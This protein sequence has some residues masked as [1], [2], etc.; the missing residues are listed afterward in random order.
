MSFEPR[1]VGF[2]CN[3]CSYA[4]ADGAGASR[5]PY[6]QN[7]SSIRVMCSAR[8]EPGLVLEA[9]ALGA[10]GVLVCGCHPGDCHYL[11]G[12][13][14]TLRRH[15]LLIRLLASL[16]VE[17]ERVRLEWISASEGARFAQVVAEFTEALR[18]LGPCKVKPGLRELGHG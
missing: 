16:G 5:T 4:G 2:L 8:V 12:N 17:P 6:P 7:L 10:D 3:W 1:I 13:H 9:L 15:R 11:E 14:K 18:A